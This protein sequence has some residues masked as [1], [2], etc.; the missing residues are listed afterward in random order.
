MSEVKIDA[1]ELKGEEKNIIKELADFLKE[2]TG[3]EVT[4]ESEKLT[5]KGEGAAVSKKY[6]RVLL[7]KFLHKHEL[8][9]YFRVISDVEDTL[10]VKERKL[11]EEE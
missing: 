9:D 1:S 8:K 5:V 11:P 7:K 2:K 3:A 6:L 4:T 10:K